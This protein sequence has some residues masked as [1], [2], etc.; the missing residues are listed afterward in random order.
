MAER[1][2]SLRHG[3]S[4]TRRWTL[5]G[6][7]AVAFAF[8]YPMQ[9]NGYNQTAHYAL[10]RSL[11]IHHV[12]NIDRSR[13]EVGDLST[14]DAAVYEGH[15]YATRAPGLPFFTVPAML[16]LEASGMRTTGDPTRVIWALHLW[17]LVLPALA[18]VLLVGLLAERLERGFGALAAVTAGLA[19]LV[20]PF[21]T[22]FF[23]HVPS[24]ALG[25]AAFAAL[26]YERDGPP[27]LRLV[28]AA[29]LLAGLAITTEYPLVFVAGVLALY[30]LAGR[31]RL[32]SRAAA[33]AG[34]VAVG[35]LPLAIFNVWAFGTPTH[36]AHEDFFAQGES[37]GVF[38]FTLPDLGQ[39]R[40]LLVSSMGILT[41][42]PVTA[43][44]VVGAVLMYRRGRRAESLVVLSVAA[45][46]LLY[47]AS[48][49]S[50]SPF[51]GLGPPRYLVTAVPFLA[52][53]LSVAFRRFPLTTGALAVVSGFQMVVMTSTGPLAA[54]DGDWLGRVGRREFV[55]T[56]A[57]IVGVTGWYTIAAYFAA[58]A[59]AV[60][61][62][63]AVTRRP[64]LTRSELPLAVAAASAWAL[65]ALT[66]ENPNGAP[67]G[68]RY[69]VATAAL[70]VA[71]AGVLAWRYGGG[72]WTPSGLTF[73][74][75]TGRSQRA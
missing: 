17:G 59:L 39:A 43:A 26:W 49:R 25:L 27:R 11:A 32:A 15:Y 66:A 7:A 54:Y 34:G 29:G 67:P 50:L 56:G 30:G 40:D 48:L 60:V 10:I 52:V 44:G 75:A 6:L 23:S 3:Q 19:T 2:E 47:N 61:A 33:Y 69:V 16:V 1:G 5:V 4:A 22:L 74:R 71:A 31:P 14:G 18:L 53:P 72:R 13:G 12:P 20:L 46:Y 58:V 62:A 42:A 63:A 28:A 36:I 9:V 45:L 55:Q 70:L 38:G 41:I 51:G 24:A 8:A 35:V 21:A 57:S 37:P 65:V 73:P 64:E 68:D